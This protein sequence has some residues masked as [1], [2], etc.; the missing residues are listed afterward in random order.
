[1]DSS[2]LDRLAINLGGAL[3]AALSGSIVCLGYG[4]VVEPEAPKEKLIK[5]AQGGGLL[6]MGL[7]LWAP[8]WLRQL[9]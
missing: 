5:R 9:W 3:T 4:L 1:M 2:E 7:Y 6:V 8:I